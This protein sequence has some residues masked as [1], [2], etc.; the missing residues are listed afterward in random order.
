M[1][2]VFPRESAA[3]LKRNSIFPI[4]TLRLERI[5]HRSGQLV[6]SLIAVQQ[7][8]TPPPPRSINCLSRVFVLPPASFS[9]LRL[10]QITGL[11]F[12]ISRFPRCRFAL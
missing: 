4:F 8:S 2:C 6:F 1:P 12:S 7:T 11:P 5:N 10:N 3:F 9:R